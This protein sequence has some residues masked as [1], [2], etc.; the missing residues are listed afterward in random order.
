MKAELA[1]S[2][3]GGGGGSSAI[4]GGLVDEEA[5][6]KIKEMEEQMKANQLAMLEMEK[7]WE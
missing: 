2:G 1:K 6:A 3:G 5:Q 4:Q 7:S